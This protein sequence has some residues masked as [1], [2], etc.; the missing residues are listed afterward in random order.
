M[1]F[2]DTVKVWKQDTWME[3][4]LLVVVFDS[5]FGLSYG[6]L[7]LTFP[8]FILGVHAQTLIGKE[9]L[10]YLH[11]LETTISV[12]LEILQL[13][14]DPST[15]AATHFGMGMAVFLL[16]PVVSSTILRGSALHSLTPPQMTW[17]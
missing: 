8:G 12:T 16:V 7:D 4:L 15:T 1:D 14:S 10:L 5:T 13:R 3:F 2:L 17:R 6:M 9:L 11:L